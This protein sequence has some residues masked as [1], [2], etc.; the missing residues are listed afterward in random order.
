MLEWQ[1]GNKQTNKHA[2]LERQEGKQLI[3]EFSVLKKKGELSLYRLFSLTG[4][5]SS[6]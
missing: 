3:I 6:L 4:A 5:D 1:K 2:C